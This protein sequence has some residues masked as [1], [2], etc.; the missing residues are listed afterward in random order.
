MIG[1]ICTYGT[2]QDFSQELKKKWMSKLKNKALYEKRVT[3]KLKGEIRNRF[4]L[5]FR[6]T[7][8]N[9]QT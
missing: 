4:N 9:C 3:I 1:S 5:N 8:K 2:V 6:K 7:S